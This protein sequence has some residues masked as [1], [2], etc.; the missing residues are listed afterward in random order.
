MSKSKI[1]LD[2][3][4]A[5]LAAVKQQFKKPDIQAQLADDLAKELAADEVQKHLAQDKV[6][7]AANAVDDAH[8]PKI[9]GETRVDGVLFSDEP[10]MSPRTMSP[11]K[12][13]K[14][15]NKIGGAY[16]NGVW[17]PNAATQGEHSGGS[18]DYYQLYVENPL[19]PRRKP[20]TVD[21]TDVIQALGM[22]YAEGNVFKALWR[23]AAA[24]KGKYKRGYDPVYDADKIMFFGPIILDAA[25]RGK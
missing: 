23:T 22:N 12:R 11:R 3:L 24:R 9:T 15:D 4:N 7:D 20:Y 2:G 18:V 5:S 16:I 25:K 17:T 6:R 19:M 13:V 10:N 1:A 14:R 8:S 21:C